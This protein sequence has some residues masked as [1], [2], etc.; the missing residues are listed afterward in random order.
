MKKILI[1]LSLCFLGFTAVDMQAQGFLKGLK[2]KAEKTLKEAEKN[3]GVK[4]SVGKKDNDNSTSNNSE[5]ASKGNASSQ[6]VPTDYEG[7]P[8][9]TSLANIHQSTIDIPMKFKAPD[10]TSST[11]HVTVEK[12]THD[13]SNFFNGVA[14]IYAYP[15]NKAFYIDK[16]GNKL[17]E[18]DILESYP[19]FSKDGFAIENLTKGCRIRSIDG[20][21]I[22]EFP[23]AKN[24]SQF[25]N[26]VAAIVEMED[27]L[28]PFNIYWVDTNGNKT[29]PQFA[30]EYVPSKL[31]NYET[32]EFLTGENLNREISDGLIAFPRPVNGLLKWGFRN[33]EGKV[34]IEPAYD[35][36]GDF[37]E[38]LAAVMT[39]TDNITKWG[40]ID[41]SGKMVIPQ[42]FTNRPSDFDSGVSFVL[43]KNGFGYYMD[44]TGNF[45]LGP[46]KGFGN[47]H[48][49]GDLFYISPFKGGRA[50]IGFF[51]QHPEIEDYYI[52][53]YAVVDPSMNKLGWANLKSHPRMD[54]NHYIHHEGKY[55]VM[56]NYGGADNWVRFNPDNFD[57]IG[58]PE[59]AIYQEDL[60][61]LINSYGGKNGFVNT[62]FDYEILVEES[63]F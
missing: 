3:L 2:E 12:E 50:I 52:P 48:G 27:I 56:Q 61:L 31:F 39:I 9:P 63:Q 13:I 43:D 23:L 15:S 8:I 14:Y 35:Y 45:K 44:K 4:K 32:T 51:T 57:R 24:G 55:Y 10:V 22:K 20:R 40:F 26:G 1:T 7:N 54:F 38:G 11:K 53:V 16:K 41:R 6:S 42:K 62:D 58:Q 37:S 36:V 49:E 19:E 5:S 59:N 21:I 28:K 47:D 30:Y 29:L 60:M 34:I 18:T 25:R 17:F 46:V 33:L